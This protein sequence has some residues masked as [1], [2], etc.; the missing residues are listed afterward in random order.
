M[1]L[2]CDLSY[3]EKFEIEYGT[4]RSNSLIITLCG[5]YEYIT[6]NTTKKI[7]P[8]NPVIFR[9]GVSFRK[10][11]INPISYIIIRL[12]HSICETEILEYDETDI[13]RLRNSV[14]H[15]ENAILEKLP[16]RIIEHFVNDILLTSKQKITKENN[17]APV[18]KYISEHF[19]ENINLK[20]LAGITG[21]SIQTLINKFKSQY[22][23]TPI[24]CITDFRIS[25]AK[26]LL[27]N[28]SL[29]I[30]QIS[31]SCGYNDVYYFSN[32]FKKAVGLSP[33][34]F[35]QSSTL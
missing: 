14:F 28:T 26:D 19:S 20:T 6:K 25:K 35:R 17:I 15:I 32:S 31:E 30:S 1:V 21:Y 5:E 3:K 11:I 33:L 7:L 2:H 22:G 24:N 8:F 23:I 9:K 18:Y 27:V 34:K 10:R 12:S 4:H 13:D 29:S 16:L